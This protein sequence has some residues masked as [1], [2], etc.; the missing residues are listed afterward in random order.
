MTSRTF[1][2][3]ATQIVL[4]TGERV[5]K[6]TVYIVGFAPSWELT[7]WDDSAGEHWGMN[8]LHKVAGSRPWSRW[9]QLH[10]VDTHHQ[11]DRDEHV[12]WLRESRLPVYVWA[13]HQAALLAEGVLAV[14]YPK[15]EVTAMFGKYF[16]NTVSWMIAHAIY[17]NRSKIGVYGVD[18]AQ[19]SEYN[20]QRP[21]CEFFLGWA[22][23]RGIEIE[24]PPTSDLLKSPFLYGAEDHNP[25]RVKMEGRLAELRKRREDMQGQLNQLQGQS[26][27]LQAMLHQLAGA[28]EDTVYWLRAWTL[29]Q[30]QDGRKTS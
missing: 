25:L 10:D 6:P 9:Y 5:L 28:E 11:N 16:T 4:A 26:Q 20:H 18:M 29:P 8:A 1:E 3:H 7:P 21:S 22:A 12:G 14:P 30:T 27:N 2:P 24:I 17:E 19:D 15:A 23:G 13:E